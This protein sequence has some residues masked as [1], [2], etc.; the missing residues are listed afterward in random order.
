MVL[1]VLVNLIRVLF[2]ARRIADRAARPRAKKTAQH[3]GCNL[4]FATAFLIAAQG[5]PVMVVYEV[6]KADIFNMTYDG[7]ATDY[8]VVTSTIIAGSFLVDVVQLSVYLAMM[9]ACKRCCPCSCCPD[10]DPAAPIVRCANRRNGWCAWLSVILPCSLLIVS[11]GFVVV[12]V[13]ALF[14]PFEFAIISG[15]L[16]VLGGLFTLLSTLPNL[17]QSSDPEGKGCL[18]VR[19]SAS[20]LAAPLKEVSGE[21]S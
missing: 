12:V 6:F 16:T 4:G 5:Y 1:H 21:D 20:P 10:E 18:L 2:A 14:S 9:C 8:V 19:S 15:S 7:N 3:C 11:C 17:V 13:S